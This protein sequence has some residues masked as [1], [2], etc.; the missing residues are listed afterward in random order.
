MIILA[1]KSPTRTQLLVNAGLEFEC[2][3]ARIDE[4]VIE[5]SVSSK[6][7][8]QKELTSL[9]ADAKALNV[10][11]EYPHA[12]VIGSDQTLSFD[13]AY[14]HK[15]ENF[16]ALRS[17]LMALS[18]KS[19]T[20]CS[21]VSIVQHNKVIWQ[22]QT[23][24]H[25]TMHDFNEQQADEIIDLEGEKLLQ[26]VGGYR[27]EGPSIRLFSN[28]EGDYFTVLGLPLLPLLSALRDLKA[29]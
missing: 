4:R 16:A 15:P 7:F 2:I 10:S 19:H 14:L 23:F 28:I 26:S 3:P 24:A 17:Q 18:G 22:H 9:L 5:A 21:A 6:Q 8:D 13:G 11:K 20:L 29:I 27:L 1:S 12:L 25:L